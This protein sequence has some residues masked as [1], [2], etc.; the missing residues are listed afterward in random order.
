VSN[1]YENRIFRTHLHLKP[2]LH[3]AGEQ[4][5]L[6]L[7]GIKPAVIHHNLK[8]AVSHHVQGPRYQ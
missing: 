3:L 8:L 5:L 2:D 6:S 4:R 1:L 7:P